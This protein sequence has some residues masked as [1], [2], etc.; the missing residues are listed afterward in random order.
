MKSFFGKLRLTARIPA[1]DDSSGACENMAEG[2]AGAAAPPLALLNE[3]APRA[4]G[5]RDAGV[6]P[7]QVA[8]RLGDFIERIPCHLLKSGERDLNRTLLFDLD[9][10]SERIAGGIMTIPLALV[11]EAA[12]DIFNEAAQN[13]QETEIRFPWLRIFE[14]IKDSDQAKD[15]NNGRS[16]RQRIQRH[17]ENAKVPA[18]LPANDAPSGVRGKNAKSNV[19]FN[20]KKGP[21][22]D[23]TKGLI[24]FPKS[25]RAAG[26]PPAGPGGA[27]AKPLTA[28]AATPALMAL[29]DPEPK[30]GE[31]HGALPPVQPELRVADSASAPGADLTSGLIKGSLKMESIA[32]S[33]RP[34]DY[35]CRMAALTAQYE[36]ALAAAR[37]EIA[38]LKNE[39]QRALEE[40]AQAREEAVAQVAGERDWLVG[41]KEAAIKEREER[42]ANITKDH[43]AALVTLQE[44]FEWKVRELEAGAAASEAKLAD[45]K[46][47]HERA[48][49]E[50]AWA[51][52]QAVAQVVWERD[53]L[54]GEKEAAI[55]ERE[56]RLATITRDHEAALVTLREEFDGKIREIV[57]ANE[58]KSADLKNEHQRALEESA[59]ARE[60]A[61]ALVAG[62][63]DKSIR[64]KEAAIKER[65]EWLAD[66]TRD[67]EVA[68]LALREEF[69]ENIWEMGAAA[70][71]N[72]VH[73][74]SLR[75]EHQRALIESARARE[76]EVAQ[77][78]GERENLIREKEAA[79]KEHDERL[80]AIRLELQALRAESDARR[81]DADRILEM[82]QAESEE[83]LQYERAAAE[84]R[85]AASRQELEFACATLSAERDEACAQIASRDLELEA[86]GRA[87]AQIE[88]DIAAYRTRIKAVLAERDALSSEGELGRNELAGAKH[89]FAQLQAEHEKTLREMIGLRTQLAENSAALREQTIR[90]K[91][92]EAENARVIAQLEAEH[93]W[94]I[95]QI[96]LEVQRNLSAM[97][98]ETEEAAQRR[99]IV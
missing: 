7:D 50:S 3:S 63:R 5:D 86:R 48:L 91:K 8:L 67:H 88:E 47:G 84:D 26:P 52:E 29:P 35:E 58:T 41:E 49:E 25:M 18:A 16:L 13:Q 82:L 98:R 4:N 53:W 51:R 30:N 75:S 46:S 65:E 74:A 68:L 31:S 38:D 10:L 15:E 76:Q 85:L 93:E 40:S 43:E 1:V 33:E 34:A 81:E 60:L 44:E 70:M 57:A 94:D 78:T 62:E 66:M 79:A 64:K 61:V 19:W 11:L 20:H 73:I 24:V 69:E 28:K 56:E 39:H 87:A 42:L 59:R 77:V 80:A 12:P 71:A 2:V 83:A 55:K 21:Q 97:R 6:E 72:E 22:G 92:A 45:L 9:D 32:G 36:S 95:G 99:E 54:A 23:G 17:S 89:E 27:D 90:F 96:V 37:A 14:V